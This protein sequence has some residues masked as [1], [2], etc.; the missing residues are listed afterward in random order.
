MLMQIVEMTK[1]SREYVADALLR[2]AD[3]DADFCG[4]NG[5]E[6]LWEAAEG[7]ETNAEYA[8]SVAEKKPTITEMV[9]KFVSMW[10]DHDSYYE[11]YELTITKFD[12]ILAISIAYVTD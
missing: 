4:D 12:G 5:Y 10:M 9:V 6:Y 11:D 1:C 7:F 8:L 2:L 3:H